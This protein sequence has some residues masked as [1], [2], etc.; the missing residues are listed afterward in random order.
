MWHDGLSHVFCK[1]AQPSKQDHEI[2][3]VRFGTAEIIPRICHR[4]LLFGSFDAQTT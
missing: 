3:S 4:E 1:A 2:S